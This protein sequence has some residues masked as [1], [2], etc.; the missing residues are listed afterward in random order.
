M[1]PGRCA[2]STSRRTIQR[3]K[4][5]KVLFRAFIQTVGYTDPSACIHW[6]R[7]SWKWDCPDADAAVEFEGMLQTLIAM[8]KSR[9]ST[10]KRVIE[11]QQKGEAFLA[12]QNEPKPGLPHPSYAFYQAASQARLDNLLTQ[13]D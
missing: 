7:S 13:Q 5:M 3:R 1:E 4:T 9:K 6:W 12:K 11:I 2:N 8:R 10:E